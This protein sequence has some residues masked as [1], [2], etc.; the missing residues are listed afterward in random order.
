MKKVFE[1]LKILVQSNYP[2]LSEKDV[3]LKCARWVLLPNLNFGNFTP[4]EMVKLGKGQKVE[5]YIQRQI[6]GN[7]P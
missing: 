5:K 2:D 6:E 7:Q 3:A 4:E 1:L